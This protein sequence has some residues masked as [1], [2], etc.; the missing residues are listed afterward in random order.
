MYKEDLGHAA[1]IGDG[2]DA[3]G[4]EV[5]QHLWRGD[6]AIADVQEGQVGQQEVDGEA[7]MC[8]TPDGNNDEN[9]SPQ[10]N[11]VEGQEEEKEDELEL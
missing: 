3:P 8:V 11:D 1:F 7:Q 2:E 10:G 6:G 5:G 4:E 9:V